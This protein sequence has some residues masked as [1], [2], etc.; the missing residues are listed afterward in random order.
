VQRLLSFVL[1]VLCASL[2]ATSLVAQ[3]AGVAQAVISPQ[4]P[5]AGT[6]TV[7]VGGGPGPRRAGPAVTGMP[8]SAEQVNET[9]QTLADGT[10]IRQK[11]RTTVMYRDSAGRTRTETPVGGPAMSGGAKMVRIVDVV[12]GYEYT[13]DD[14]NKVAHRVMVQVAQPMPRR[15][16]TGAAGTGGG[17]SVGF[18]GPT[19]AMPVPRAVAPGVPG[20]MPRPEIQ[21][22]DLGTQMIEGVT[23]RGRRMTQTWPVD[24]VGNDR[25]IV[26]V[27]ENWFSEQLGGMAVLSKSNDPRH[28][29]TTTTLKNVS[30]A[31]PDPSLFQPP[32]GYQIVDEN[33]SFQIA[34]PRPSPS[35][36]QNQ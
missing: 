9:V 32:P 6:M 27:F 4:R 25:P 21:S 36:A 16:A 29:E 7:G 19:A 2:L 8:Y 24:S 13:L 23:A 17:T 14:Q 28:G 22:E 5:Q 11:Q 26:A 30:L 35:A 20:G 10:H 15:V 12:G 33:G 1:T 18:L 3:E 31:E 34:V